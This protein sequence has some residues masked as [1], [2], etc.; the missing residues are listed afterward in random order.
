MSILADIREILIAEDNSADVRLM[1]EALQAL[2]PPI[3]VRIARDGKEVMFLLGQFE[4]SPDAP[5]PSL[6]FL[7]Y[8][9]PKME[10]HRV[11]QF[12]KNSSHLRDIPVIVLT[13]S[14]SEDL[15]DEAYELGANCYLSKPLDLDSFL[16][17][18]RAAATFWLNHPLNR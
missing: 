14:S 4:Q 7:D 10:P 8:H 6:I 18:V 13:T 5:K 9:L 3:K 12:V 16:Q 2:S 17:T 11:L 1:R 15:I